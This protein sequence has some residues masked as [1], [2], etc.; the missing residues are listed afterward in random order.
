MQV[1][2]HLLPWWTHQVLSVLGFL[3]QKAMCLSQMPPA[4]HAN[5]SLSVS[6]HCH[7]CFAINI[8]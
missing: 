3:I 4:E 6:K 5:G 8:V 7:Q 1:F 2:L